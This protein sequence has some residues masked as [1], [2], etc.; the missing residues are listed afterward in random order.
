MASAIRAAIAPATPRSFTVN[1]FPSKV[2]PSV[3]FPI[4]R[5][6]S[7]RSDDRHSIAMISEAGVMSNP[8]SC[9]IPF[10]LGPN[11]VTM[12]LSD[13]SFTSR[14]LFHTI[15]FRANPSA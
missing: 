1:G 10:V 14:T 8:D 7:S 5:F 4:L 13:L 3:M 2:H 9:G 12:F 11:P 6:R 15:S